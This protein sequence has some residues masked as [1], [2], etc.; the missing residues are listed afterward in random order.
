MHLDLEVVE[1]MFCILRATL[2]GVSCVASMKELDHPDLHHWFVKKLVTMAMDRHDKQ[3]EMS[4]ALLSSLYSEVGI[5]WIHAQQHTTLP[6][7]A[8]AD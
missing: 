2:N 4:S 6:L 8:Y 1:L 5:C 7:L 3:R